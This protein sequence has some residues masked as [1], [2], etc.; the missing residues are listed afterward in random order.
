MLAHA[1]AQHHD[2]DRWNCESAKQVVHV[3]ILVA[4]M[5]RQ[6][7]DCLIRV[8]GLPV[9]GIVNGSLR[10]KPAFMM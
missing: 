10:A 9:G 8:D 5:A 7:S 3:G 2:G 4:R 1:P 6:S